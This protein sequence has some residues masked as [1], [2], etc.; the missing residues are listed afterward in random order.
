MAKMIINVEV[1]CKPCPKCWPL[2]E[3]IN[4]IV[5]CMAMKEH[6]GMQC[7]FKHN[8]NILEA[9][10][11]GCKVVDLPIV[12]VNGKV[13]FVGRVK[14]EHIIRAK[15]LEILHEGQQGTF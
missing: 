7:V 14:G 4:T 9:E 13:A 5:S 15:I 10:K 6:V 2:E 1:I 11:Y 12:L 3:K 8:R